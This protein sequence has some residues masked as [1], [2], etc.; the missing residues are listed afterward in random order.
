MCG[1]AL[2]TSTRYVTT[3]PVATGS[4]LSAIVTARSADAAAP[5]APV[6]ALASRRPSR[7]AAAA[8]EPSAVAPRST[9]VDA[10]AIRRTRCRGGG[11]LLE[12]VGVT[13]MAG[14]Y[15]GR[16][17]DSRVRN[18]ASGAAGNR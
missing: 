17:G 16:G 14:A 8:G 18:S 5:A 6:G 13:C 3:W 11:V 15:L 4:G 12:V 9:M 7:D 2:C 1:P 10:P